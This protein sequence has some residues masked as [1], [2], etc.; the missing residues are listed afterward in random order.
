MIGLDTNVL[1]RYLLRDDPAQSR[2]ATHFIEGQLKESRLGFVSV[3]TMLEIVWVLES[4]YRFS[5]A[6]I[7]GWI[8]LCLQ[9]ETLH[10]QNAPEVH[11]AMLVLREERGSFDDALIGELSRWA[12]CDFTV[13]FD[14]RA[15]RLPGFRL[16]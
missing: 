12:G 11:E 1:L 16:I 15:A 14:K 8:E 2:A 13:T 5:D 4:V 3:A 7:A 6:Q 10:V 9:I